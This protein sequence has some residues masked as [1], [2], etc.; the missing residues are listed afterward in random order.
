VEKAKKR[1][2]RA[3]VI[4]LLVTV[5]SG[6]CGTAEAATKAEIDEAVEHG[7]AWLAAQQNSSTGY[8]KD[9]SSLAGA[10]GLALVKLQ[11][12]A[13]ELG[14]TPFDPYYPYK[15]NVEKGLAYLFSQMSIMSIS[16]QPAGNPDTDGDGIGVYVNT[17]VYETGIA[18][19]AIAASR[20]PDRVVNSPGS[21]VNGW[22]YKEVLQDM[23]DYMAFG[24]CDSG[25]G[26]GGWRYSPNSGADNSCSGYAASGLGYAESP[27]YGFNC[28]IPQFVKDELKIW[29]DYIQTDGDSNDGGSG[30]TVP[31]NMVN[32][33]KTGNLIFQMTL[34]GISSEDP[35]MQRALAYI[36]RKWNESSQDPGWGNPAYGGT[37]HCQVM[38]CAA[39]G[40]WYSGI[41]DVN[42]RDWYANFADAIVNRQQTGGN[43]PN[44]PYGGTVLATEWALLTLEMVTSGPLHDPVILEKV[45]DVNGGDCV[46]PGRE[47]TYTIDYNY[48]VGPSHQYF[49]E[50]ADFVQWWL[51]DDCTSH[52]DCNGIDMNTDGIVNFIDFAL[53]ANN[54]GKEKIISNVNI[55]DYLPDEVEFISSV[56]VPDEIIDSNKIIWH[57]GTLSSGEP[58]FVTLK[59]KVRCTLLGG[60]IINRCEMTGNCIDP[61]YAQ[62]NT[63]VCTP[64]LTKVNNVPESNYVA[65]DA[66]ITYSICYAANGYGDTNVVI[67]DYLPDGVSYVS[68]EP[69]GDYH[70]GNHTVTWNIALSPDAYGCI[71]LVARVNWSI[72]P[73]SN[74]TNCCKMT[75]DCMTSG[76]TACDRPICVDPHR[77]RLDF[78]NTTDNNDANTQTG[79][80][81][82]ILADSGKEVNGITIDLGENIESRHHSDPYGRWSGGVYYPRAGESRCIYR[83][84]FRTGKKNGEGKWHNL[85]CWNG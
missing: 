61:I 70:P 52:N 73:G 55:I 67:I 41:N 14:Y 27:R 60:T 25:N 13:F 59:V 45:D 62:E 65:P 16:T 3:F 77:I 23:V 5:I 51:A 11:E 47:I 50:L 46:W 36:G 69:S 15:D 20:A 33:L 80:A 19:M 72:L 1:A 31:N 38:Y 53:F 37:P 66:N 30:Y 24:Q 63:P 17:S 81:K 12:R 7:V 22:T 6:I 34:A 32:T 35:N 10:T 29:I 68:S 58:G 18:M 44:D 43:W 54:W 82:F 74:I 40:L 76:V 79:F 78:N 2:K 64:T 9:G 85:L 8:W 57:I 28:A 83:Q 49:E 48:P 75:G 4:L 21:P 42:Q 39:N 84:L 56:P 71:N 26:R